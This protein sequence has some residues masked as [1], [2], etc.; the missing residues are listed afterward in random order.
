MSE[1]NEPGEG[2]P[3]FLAAW[4]AWLCALASD[5]DAALAAADLYAGLGPE[6]RDAWL[7]ALDEDAQGLSVPAVALYAPLLAVEDDDARRARIKDAITHGDASS[8]RGTPLRTLS[9]IARGGE[10]V[11]ALVL[12]AYLQFVR[13]L[14]CRFHPDVGFSWA[15]HESLMDE[16][17]APRSG[18]LVDGVALEET[19][20]APIV[21]AL[22]HAILAQRR[23]GEELPSSLTR[24]SDLFDADFE[25]IETFDGAL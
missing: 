19:P 18:A 24:F 10:H 5:A 22:A 25:A 11:V 17:H 12:P 4:R 23:R 16:T 9:G 3:R 1:A 15:R 2:D 6:A 20:L 21:E 13:V 14:W 8:W 7:A